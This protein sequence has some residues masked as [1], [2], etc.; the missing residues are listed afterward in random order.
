MNK[1]KK[2]AGKMGFTLAELMVVIALMAVLATL[3]V[4]AVRLAMDSSK[5]SVHRS[6]AKAIT[7]FLESQYAKYREYCSSAA[8]T[9]TGELQCQSA[10]DTLSYTAVVTST[11]AANGIKLS[12]GGSIN[13]ECATGKATEGGGAVTEIK[14]DG[15]AI[16]VADAACGKFTSFEDMV[17]NGNTT[18]TVTPADKTAFPALP[19]WPVV[20]TP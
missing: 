5:E 16:A 19:E 4:G 17:I 2:T 6:N 8:A 11:A 20:A 18:D 13:G 3:I 1:I 15:Y 14:A 9:P 12:T 7:A 10:G